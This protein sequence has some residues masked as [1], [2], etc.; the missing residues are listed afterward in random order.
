MIIPF[1]KGDP[2]LFA[3]PESLMAVDDVSIPGMDG[4]SHPEGKD[5]LNQ[6]PVFLLRER[7]LQAFKTQAT[8]RGPRGWDTI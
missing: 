3:D 6:L 8:C 4:T 5:V 2:V 7:D 1:R